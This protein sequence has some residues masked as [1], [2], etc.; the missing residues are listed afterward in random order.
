MTVN[1]AL[2]NAQDAKDQD[3]AAILVAMAMMRVIFTFA[4]IQAKKG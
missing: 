4:P 2:G 1:S 3:S